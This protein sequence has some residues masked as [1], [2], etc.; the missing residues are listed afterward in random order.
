MNNTQVHIHRLR[1]NSPIF[2]LAIMI[3]LCWNLNHLALANAKEA[4]TQKKKEIFEVA[5]GLS[6]EKLIE[7]TVIVGGILKPKK[8]S[9]VFPYGEGIVKTVLIKAGSPVRKGDTIVI[10]EPADN[11]GEFSNQRLEAKANGTLLMMDVAEGD[12]VK[13]GQHVATIAGL[14]TASIKFSF[15]QQDKETLKNL[16][17]IRLKDLPSNA[18]SVRATLNSF[19]S[20]PNE[21][22]LAYTG[23]ID[24]I[25]ENSC[26][27]LIGN[28][29][30]V[31]LVRSASK[32]IAVKKQGVDLKRSQLRV[33]NEKNE[34]EVRE[35]K[36]SKLL[37]D[38]II[39]KS[40]VTKGE[41]VVL[42]A[43][44]PRRKKLENGDPVII[45]K[46]VIAGDIDK[47]NETKQ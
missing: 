22:T 2:L 34:I 12:F 47:K 31:E 3:T 45:K 36:I 46:S 42:S 44:T 39:L 26:K 38:E 29:L 28:Y 5:V 35:I 14:K 9:Y 30:E 32:Y 43:N 19:N 33:V 37:E 16:L 21:K 11:L 41:K 15:T 25:C 17:E 27:P 23:F 10:I 7:D 1:L 6:Y 18:G 40:G 20:L 13:K 8:V 4:N 24:V